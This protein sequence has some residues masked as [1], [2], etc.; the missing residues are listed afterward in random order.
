MDPGRKTTPGGKGSGP[1]GPRIE[2]LIIWRMPGYGRSHA[3]APAPA[4]YSTSTRTHTSR[5]GT[6]V[7]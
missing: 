3:P 2:Q 5:T 7:S 4:R 6:V 1:L